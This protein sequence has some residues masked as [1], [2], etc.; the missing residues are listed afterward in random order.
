MVAAVAVASLTRSSASSSSPSFSGAF[1]CAVLALPGRCRGEEVRGARQVGGL[2]RLGVL[3]CFTSH[4]ES[5]MQL[6]LF[7]IL[8]L[9]LPTRLPARPSYMPIA[10]LDLAR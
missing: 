6:A 9:L 4:C 7:L 10:P 2:E 3:V 5:G 8:F 1:L